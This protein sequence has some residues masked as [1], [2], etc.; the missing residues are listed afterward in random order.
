MKRNRASLMPMFNRSSLAALALLLAFH[1]RAALPTPDPD[2]GGLTLPPGFRALVVADKLGPIRY[3]TVASNG[4]IY[5]KRTRRGLVALQDTNADGRA[6][7]I[8]NFGN[9]YGS[10]TGVAIHDGWLYFSTDDAVYRY[11]MK[12]GELVPTDSAQ[13]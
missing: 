3:I 6:D 9:D 11:K 1:S 12:P 13:A 5:S 10:G 2:D 4:D 7:V 8:E